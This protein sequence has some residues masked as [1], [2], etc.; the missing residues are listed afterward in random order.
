MAGDTIGYFPQKDLYI[1]KCDLCTEA[2]TFLAQNG[3]S[4]SYELSPN[5]FYIRS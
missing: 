5:E 3:Y 1:N 2:R 4:G